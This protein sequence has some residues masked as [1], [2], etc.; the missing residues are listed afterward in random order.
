MRAWWWVGI[1]GALWGCAGAD[2][3]GVPAP[4]VEVA[5][6]QPDG[7]TDAGPGEDGGSGDAGAPD[8][9][10]SACESGEVLPLSAEG[11]LQ[12]VSKGGHLVLYFEAFAAKYAVRGHGVP[13]AARGGHYFFSADGTRA[14]SGRAFWGYGGGEGEV[15]E[16]DARSKAQTVL[17]DR[18]VPEVTADEAA[19]LIA[20]RTE[21]GTLFLY[22][23]QAR[24]KH[25]ASTQ[26]SSLGFPVGGGWAF[27]ARGSLQVWVRSSQRVVSLGRWT[28]A[29]PLPGGLLFVDAQE[30]LFGWSEHSGA[31]ALG[32]AEPEPVVAGHR[33]NAANGIAL[34]DAEGTAWVWRWDTGQVRRLTE[35]AHAVALSSNGEVVAVASGAGDASQLELISVATGER[36]Q[37]LTPAAEVQLTFNAQ[38]TTLAAAVREDD[39]WKVSVVDVAS[40]RAI[41]AADVP[42]QTPGE[43]LALEFSPDGR[44]LLVTPA[45]EAQSVYDAATGGLTYRSARAVAASG[46][47]SRWF[48]GDVLLLR[49]GAHMGPPDQGLYAWDGSADVEQELGAGTR[50]ACASGDAVYFEFGVA[51]GSDTAG[52]VAA[53]RPGGVRQV[54]SPR[55]RAVR[56]TEDGGGVV[57]LEAPADPSTDG[58]PGP[59]T[60]RWATAE[61]P[62]GTTLSRTVQSYVLGRD[63]LAYRSA[64]AACV[65]P[66]PGR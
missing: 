36:R 3:T 28:R 22:D 54:L 66:L 27:D 5:P 34:I 15:Y 8:G 35:G 9:G 60:L 6:P 20:G 37:V 19:Q 13:F 32:R 62:A 25:V 10:A 26:A 21:A 51:Q 33:A 50:I 48:D 57:F 40:G 63:H 47:Y 39:R 64:T 14:Y 17:F 61:A 12:A 56:C 4:P 2:E 49:Q 42:P 58:R 43:R 41:P 46:T 53:W 7:G 52:A 31:Q 11:E 24:V 29:E 65:A 16:L 45:G 1:L 55:A 30:M 23:T 44:L 38:G 59:G 18:S